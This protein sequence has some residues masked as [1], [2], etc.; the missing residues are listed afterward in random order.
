M[1]FR[2]KK[3]RQGNIIIAVP[4]LLDNLVAKNEETAKFLSAIKDTRV[5]V[6]HDL[7]WK[8]TPE[9]LECLGTLHKAWKEL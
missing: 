8:R 6:R 5:Y 1:R 3:Q 7:V 4:E 2:T 9:G